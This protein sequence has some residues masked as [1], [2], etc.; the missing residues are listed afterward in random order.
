MLRSLEIALTLKIRLPLKV[1]QF[2]A[3]W[4][5]NDGYLFAL[6]AILSHA[7]YVNKKCLNVSVKDVLNVLLQILLRKHQQSPIFVLSVINIFV[8]TVIMH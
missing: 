5:N 2:K 3:F 4:T 7:L 6:D 1:T 8:K